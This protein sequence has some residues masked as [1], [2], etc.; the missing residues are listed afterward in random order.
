MLLGCW[1]SP[2]RYFKSCFLQNLSPLFNITMT[3][4]DIDWRLLSKMNLFEM[5]VYKKRSYNYL[6]MVE[7]IVYG[8]ADA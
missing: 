3:F 4:V 2:C 7:D 5:G 1:A 6:S 8:F